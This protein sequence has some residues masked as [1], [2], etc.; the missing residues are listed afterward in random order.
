MLM[1]ALDD[2]GLPE[3]LNQRGARSP[4][5]RR[6][7]HRG[8]LLN[9]GSSTWPSA[10]RR[11]DTATGAPALAN[12][13]AVARPIPVRAPVTRTTGLFMTRLLRDMMW[14]VWLSEHS[15]TAT[16]AHRRH[17]TRSLCIREGIEKCFERWVSCLAGMPPRQDS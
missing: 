9:L 10:T 7:S 6:M 5:V 1:V 15:P 13:K 12:A 2:L 11:P 8:C 16:M 14:D 3:Q 17:N 4:I